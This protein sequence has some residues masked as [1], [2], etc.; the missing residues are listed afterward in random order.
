[1][2]FALDWVDL[3]RDG[4]ASFLVSVFNALNFSALSTMLTANWFWSTL[5]ILLAFTLCYYGFRFHRTVHA[6]F[7][8]MILG[9]FGWYLGIAANPNTAAIAWVYA[10]MSVMIG[11][12]GIYIGYFINVF[13]MG[14]L[15]SI[16][17]SAPFRSAFLGTSI[18]FSLILA[19]IGCIIYAKFKPVMTA[20]YGGITIAVIF[21]RVD[22]I[23]S[24][25]IGVFC[26]ITGI[27]FQH[28]MVKIYQ[29]HLQKELEEQ[30]KKYPYGPGIA[31]GWDDPTLK[32]IGK[33]T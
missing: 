25:I 33:N 1:M 7:G 12:F 5:S 31:Y 15:F 16:A 30:V 13:T 18:F 21:Y 10:V 20:V 28:K 23:L 26:M 2:L 14:F 24:L 19:F 29:K 8:A 9:T 4:I 11:F 6:V 27:L 32:D 17:L 22:P 3:V